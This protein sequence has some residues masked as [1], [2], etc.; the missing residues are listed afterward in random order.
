M[1][2]VLIPKYYGPQKAIF[3]KLYTLQ[4]TR[5]NLLEQCP[6]NY[7]SCTAGQFY[8]HRTIP[9]FYTAKGYIRKSIF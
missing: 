4:T 9:L 6:K 3:K 7:V 2:E 8:L 5:F 1:S